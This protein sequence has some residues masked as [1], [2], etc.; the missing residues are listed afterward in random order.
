[1]EKKK[2][3]LLHSSRTY[4][5]WGK[6]VIFLLLWTSL[7]TANSTLFKQYGVVLAK[8]GKYTLRQLLPKEPFI[9]TFWV[10]TNTK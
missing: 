7:L 4:Y 8:R 1:M 5:P 2:Q 3:A 10:R 9:K 6:G